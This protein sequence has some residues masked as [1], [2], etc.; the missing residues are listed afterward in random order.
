[1]DLKTYSTGA[2]KRSLFAAQL[3][4]QLQSNVVIWKSCVQKKRD[5]ASYCVLHFASGP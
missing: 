3:H 2:F 1:M 4:L 5:A